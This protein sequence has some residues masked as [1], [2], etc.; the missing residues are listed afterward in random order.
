MKGQQEGTG[1]YLT[2][3]IQSLQVAHV[4]HLNVSLHQ[5][6]KRGCTAGL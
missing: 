3:H 6:I 4:L 2:L 1:T 5:T